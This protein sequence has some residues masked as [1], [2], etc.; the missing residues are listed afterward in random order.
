MV[1]SVV[2]TLK[3]AFSNEAETSLHSGST[4]PWPNIP[5]RSQLYFN[6]VDTGHESLR[7]QNVSLLEKLFQKNSC[8]LGTCTK[9]SKGLPAEFKTES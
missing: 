9:N 8:A 1:V 4:G 5:E 6:T 2:F 7:Y 3:M